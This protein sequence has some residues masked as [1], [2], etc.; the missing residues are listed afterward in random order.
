M[1]KLITAIL[2]AAL[3]LCACGKTGETSS[4]DAAGESKGGEASVSVFEPV[5]GN[6]GE[7]EL[8]RLF[9]GNLDCVFNIIRNPLPIEPEPVADK[10]HYVTGRFTAYAELEAY[11]NAIYCADT[12]KEL[13]EYE[14]DGH[15]RYL[16]HNGRLCFDEYCAA[17]A[18]YYVDWADYTLTVELLDEKDCYFTV[19]G[20]AEYPAD[21]PKKEPYAVLAH[22]VCENGVW[23]LEQT[24]C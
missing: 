11:I 19:V 6:I 3:L 2:A 22:A 24:Y 12:A 20:T 16:D 15:R 21:E 4:A 5:K 23:K 14:L 8:R 18:G 17:A 9:E 7:P 13:L 1:K 10:L